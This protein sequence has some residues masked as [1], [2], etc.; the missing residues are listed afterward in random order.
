MNTEGST[1]TNVYTGPTSRQESFN[2]QIFCYLEYDC[3]NNQIY[4][5]STC[6]CTT[7]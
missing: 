5:N 6:N 7:G 2:L 1:F 3:P 4:I